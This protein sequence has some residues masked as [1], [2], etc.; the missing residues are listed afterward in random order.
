M[1]NESEKIVK[2]ERIDVDNIY[3]ERIYFRWMGKKNKGI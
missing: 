3:D 1:E 2:R